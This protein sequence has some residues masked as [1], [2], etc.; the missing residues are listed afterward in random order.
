[1]GKDNEKMTEPRKPRSP[2]APRKTRK[3][4][5]I[6][7]KEQYVK[8]KITNK[9]KK[10]SH[11]GMIPVD[12]I[13]ISRNLERNGIEIRFPDIPP[14]DERQWMKEKGLKWSSFLGI[15]WVKYDDGIY[16]DLLERFTDEGGEL[17]T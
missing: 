12:R 5:V 9:G 4:R 17:L 11:P 15:W 13:T 1:M 3:P 14:E 7:G 2:R 10:K 8:D 6:K 16:R